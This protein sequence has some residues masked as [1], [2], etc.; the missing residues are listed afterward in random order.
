MKSCTRVYVPKSVKRTV[1]ALQPLMINALLEFVVP[2][3][4]SL[5]ISCLVLGRNCR[6]TAVVPMRSWNLVPAK[7]PNATKST[8]PAMLQAKSAPIFA[9][10][11]NAPIANIFNINLK[12][13]KNRRLILTWNIRET[14]KC[15]Q[16]W[17]SNP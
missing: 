6:R 17:T 5:R 13:S 2:I 1:I 7:R 3:V 4:S 8:V 15:H 16:A 11:I 10:V 12:A 14:S 9:P